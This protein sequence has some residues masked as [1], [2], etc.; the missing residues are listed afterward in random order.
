MYSKGVEPKPISIDHGI[1][2]QIIEGEM[3]GQDSDHLK[4]VDGKWIGGY[5]E[6]SLIRWRRGSGNY[7]E[8][9]GC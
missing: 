9:E 8:Q 5:G 6:E 7:N 1:W 3:V 4:H 2:K